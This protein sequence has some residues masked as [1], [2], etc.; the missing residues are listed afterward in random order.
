MEYTTQ[1]TDRQQEL[2][3]F[4]I[5]NGADLI[6]GNHPH[7]I[8]PQETYKDKL[9]TYAHGNYVFD[10]MWSE[11]TKEGVIGKYTFTGDNLTSTEFIATYITDYGR[12]QLADAERAKSILSVFAQ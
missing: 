7:W 5:D 11:E 4:A 12:S 1:I 8:Q 10:Q 9:I 3:H 6:I 2:A